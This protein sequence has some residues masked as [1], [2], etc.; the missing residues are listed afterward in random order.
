VR[1]EVRLRIQQL[2]PGGGY[3]LAPSHNIGDD[4]PL[5]NILAFFDAWRAYG[6]YPLQAAAV[7]ER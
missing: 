2:G 3:V 1:E 7:S 4:V 6:E 5:E